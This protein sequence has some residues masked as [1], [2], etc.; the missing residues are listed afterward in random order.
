[1]P[2]D[3]S[4]TGTFA[5]TLEYLADLRNFPRLV[6]VDSVSLA[7][8]TFPKLGVSIKAVIYT[9]GTPPTPTGGT[10]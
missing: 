9:L 3:I 1:M 2:V 10:H 4:L 5:Q 6:I 8:Q 7:P